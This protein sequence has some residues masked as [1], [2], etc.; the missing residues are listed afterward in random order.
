MS[1]LGGQCSTCC[2]TTTQC[3]DCTHFSAD[4]SFAGA[5]LSVS[6]NGV[7]VPASGAS[8]VVTPPA[9]VRSTCFQISD[10]VKRARFTYDYDTASYTE[11]GQ[12]A[13]GCWFIRVYAYLEMRLEFPGNE[14]TYSFFLKL[15]RD[16]GD[17]SDTGGAA[18]WSSW[19]AGG[20]DCAGG[21]PEDCQIEALDWLSTLTIAASFSYSACTCPP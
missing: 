2:G 4:D 17:C 6:V 20:N 1:I 18:T 12:D 14:C 19:Q 21:I 10:T 8:Y 11:T 9:S 3:P 5:T 13:S 15:S 16:T 7:S